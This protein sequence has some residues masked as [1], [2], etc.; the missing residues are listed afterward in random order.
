MLD[1]SQRLFVLNIFTSLHTKPEI[2]YGFQ[3]LSQLL[4]RVAVY[5]RIG[6]LPHSSEQAL[7]WALCQQDPPPLYDHSRRMNVVRNIPFGL[8]DGTRLLRAILARFAKLHH[9]TNQTA[10]SLWQTYRRTEIHERLVVVT[11]VS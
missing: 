7:R 11:R 10:R 5:A 8:L 9:R 1:D 3:S 4:R 2:I 6:K